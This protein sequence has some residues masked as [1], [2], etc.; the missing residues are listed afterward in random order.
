MIINIKASE[1]I[2]KTEWIVTI[3]HPNVNWPGKIQSGE[4]RLESAY[5]YSLEQMMSEE[6][7][8]KIMNS[9]ELPNIRIGKTQYVLSR[10]PDF[11]VMKQLKDAFDVRP[12]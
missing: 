12:W 7:V 5:M 9:G 3:T 2:D 1:S 11:R 10:V 6:F 4:Y 8:K